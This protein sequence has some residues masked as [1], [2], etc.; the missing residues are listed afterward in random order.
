M[1]RKEYMLLIGL[2]AKFNDTHGGKSGA[3]DRACFIL[4]QAIV[5]IASRLFGIT[6]KEVFQVEAAIELTKLF[7]PEMVMEVR[8]KAT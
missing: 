1:T 3:V 4:L 7:E 5:S 2:L 6:E 8:V